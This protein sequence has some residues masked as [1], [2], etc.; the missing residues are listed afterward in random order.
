M[1]A[2]DQLWAAPTTDTQID[3]LESVAEDGRKLSAE[4]DNATDK[5]PFLS[6]EV[7]C[8]F[9]TT[10][11]AANKNWEGWILY[12]HD[13][14]NYERGDESNDPDRVPDFFVPIGEHTNQQTVVIPDIPILPLKCKVLLISRCDQTTTS[15]TANNEVSERR[16]F[17]NTAQS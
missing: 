8:D 17:R 9:D 2:G 12:A 16:Y 13:G 1:S 4:I 3:T 6:L 10:A 15:S 5:Y 14:T 11:P 7:K